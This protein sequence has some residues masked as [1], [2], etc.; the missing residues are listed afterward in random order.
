MASWK[1]RATPSTRDAVDAS[2]SAQAPDLLDANIEKMWFCYCWM[3]MALLEMYY[4]AKC[5]YLVF[6]SYLQGPL[7]KGELGAVFAAIALGTQFV[8]M[9]KQELAAFK[10]RVEGEGKLWERVGAFE[11]Y[12]KYQ[13]LECE[14]DAG[15]TVVC[16]KATKGGRS[17]VDAWRASMFL[18]GQ[19]LDPDGTVPVVSIDGP[20]GEHPFVEVLIKHCSRKLA[21]VEALLIVCMRS[22]LNDLASSFHYLSASDPSQELRD[23]VKLVRTEAFVSARTRS[24]ARYEPPTPVQH[25]STV[26][27]LRKLIEIGSEALV[28]QKKDGNSDFN[29]ETEALAHTAD[30][31]SSRAFAFVKAVLEGTVDNGET[32]SPCQFI[33]A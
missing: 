16:V 28:H 19:Q 33:P 29:Q 13:V 14:S 10:Q 26:K 6:G 31:C 12:N 9:N 18:G 25:A 23:I 1:H 4:I 7:V 15:D 22:G 5:C 2:R 11:G 8:T 17:S 20:N 32:F 27:M 21:A 3:S 30:E 24:R